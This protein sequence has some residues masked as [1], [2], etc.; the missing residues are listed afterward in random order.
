MRFGLVVL[1]AA[2]TVAFSP[3]SAAMHAS[4][5]SSEPAAKSHLA[6]RPARIRLVFSEPIEGKLS[7]IT[8]ARTGNAPIVVPAAGDPRDVHA[9]IAPSDSLTPGAYRLEWR[10][11]SADGHPVDGNFTFTI[12]D[13]TLGTQP[14]PAAAVPDTEPPVAPQADEADVDWG[15]TI[16][17]APVIPGLL[18]GLALAALLATGGLLLFLALA[19]SGAAQRGCPRLRA[20]TLRLSVASAVLLVGH[21]LAW[22][23][24]TSPG[25]TFDTEWARSALGT[26]VGQIELWRTGLALLALWALGLARR[27]GI[28]LA[29]VIASLAVSGAIGH[30][31]AMQPFVAVPA[32]AIH[33]LASGVWMGGLLWLIIRP[34]ADSAELFRHDAERVSSL[35]LWAVIAVAATGALQTWLFLPTIG[36]VFIS[37]YGWFALAKTAGLL[38]LVGFGAYHRQRLVPHLARAEQSGIATLR[39]SVAREIGVMLIVILLGGL[40]AY[41]P[42]PGEGDEASMSTHGSTS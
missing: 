15:P 16:A 35:A 25:Q 17:G 3:R 39:S 32:K 33:L 37:A 28:A 5:V 40:L 6:T 24:H 31:A 22:L 21:L 30:P 9:V 26:T 36:D 19:P 7:R 18:R 4:L 42:P 29:F 20:I 34:S 41:V 11:V 2:S 8:L 13:T 12:G 27:Y 10:I 1:L 14:P 38:A 23:V